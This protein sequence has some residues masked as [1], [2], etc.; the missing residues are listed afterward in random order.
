MHFLGLLIH[1]SQARVARLAKHQVGGNQGSLLHPTIQLNRR[2][3]KVV[4]F[5]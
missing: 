5:L 3:Y 4:I 1:F 2:L